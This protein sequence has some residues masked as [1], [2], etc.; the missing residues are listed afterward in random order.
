MTIKDGNKGAKFDCDQCNYEATKKCN[1]VRHVKSRHEGVKFPCG[2]CDYKATQKGSLLEHVKSI[3]EGVKF[4]CDQ[5][6]YKAS[7]NEEGGF[8]VTWLYSK[9]NYQEEK[10][11]ELSKSF[12]YVIYS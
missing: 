10:H 9:L 3:H 4:P 8:G 2:Q 6:D 12:V 1:L 11:K 7:Y 5:C